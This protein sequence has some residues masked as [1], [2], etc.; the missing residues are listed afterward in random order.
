MKEIHHLSKI[1]DMREIL[2][3]DT[4]K[5]FHF[6]FLF[7][8]PDIYIYLGMIKLGQISSTVRIASV[9]VKDLSNNLQPSQR[10]A[11]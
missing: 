3:S 10:K 7:F 6:N 8:P 2:S 4:P 9:L 5:I 1:K 11:I